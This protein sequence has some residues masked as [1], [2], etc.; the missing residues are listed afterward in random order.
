M[1]SQHV[2]DVMDHRAREL[3]PQWG[4]DSYRAHMEHEQ[5]PYGV[6]WSSP[7]MGRGTRDYDHEPPEELQRGPRNFNHRPPEEFQRAQCYFDHDPPKDPHD[8]DPWD[9]D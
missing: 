4:P 8:V 1:G 2:K 3:S 9:F 7:N 6:P 5:D